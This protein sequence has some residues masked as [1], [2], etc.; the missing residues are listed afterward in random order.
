MNGES[1]EEEG[2]GKGCYG[3]N[4]RADICMHWQRGGPTP[5]AYAQ[6]QVKM[7]AQNVDWE[8]KVARVL[9]SFV[10]SITPLEFHNLW[11][12]QCSDKKCQ[13]L[14]VSQTSIEYVA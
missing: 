7:A 2:E 4:E 1:K 12:T 13:W 9:C 8:S 5:Q 3:K 10:Y 11:N 14:K 6:V